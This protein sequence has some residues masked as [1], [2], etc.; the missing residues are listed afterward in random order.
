M[1]RGVLM[2]DLADAMRDV[3]DMDTS[4]SDYARAAVKRFGWRDL[5]KEK[6]DEGDMVIATDGK[7]RWM[8]T[9]YASTPYLSWYGINGSHVATHWHP[10]LDLPERNAHAPSAP[11]E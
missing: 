11:Q 2:D 7:R 10:V 5:S 9:W 6:P 1:D 3:Q 8:D 4:F